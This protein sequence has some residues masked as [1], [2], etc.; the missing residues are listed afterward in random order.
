MSYAEANGVKLYVEETGSGYPIVFV[1]EFAADH[2]EWET[3]VRYFSR[4]YR[5]IT[6]AA[7]GYTPSDV[8]EAEDAYLYTHFADDIAA[9]LRHVGAAKAHVVG[10]SQGAYATLMFGLRHPQMASALVAA[11]CGS[12]SVREQREEFM[13]QCEATSHRFL[14]EGATAMAQEMGVAPSRV[15]LLNKD[16]HGWQEFVDHLGQHSAKGS[17]L[18]M[19]NYQGK[20]PSLYNFAQQFAAMTIPTLVVV[21]DEDESCIEPS[22]FLK[23]TIPTAGLFVQ[24]RT[25]HAINLEEPAVFNRE[26]QEFFSAVERGSWGRRDPRA[27]VGG[28]VQR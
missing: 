16:P 14:R 15:Q 26:V 24:P 12:G 21:G 10:L 23:R 9:V 1:H 28:H 25:G 3:Q 20:R 18:T 11:G 4:S 8:P 27:V 19:R 7:R 6:F 2:R 22:V 5:C 17:S 13:Q